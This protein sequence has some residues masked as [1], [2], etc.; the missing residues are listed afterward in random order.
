MSVGGVYG[1]R[2]TLPSSI[3]QPPLFEWR[4]YRMTH[5]A[6]RRNE[7]TV[8]PQ[9]PRTSP[10]GGQDHRRISVTAPERT[11]RR[12]PALGTPFPA[13]RDPTGTRRRYWPPARA[14]LRVE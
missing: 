10:A 5:A 8:R 14:S 6:A 2:S 7:V 3:H 11:V 4:A 9:T 12:R 1:R 13:S